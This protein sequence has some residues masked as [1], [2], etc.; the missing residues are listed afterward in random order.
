MGAGPHEK[1]FHAKKSRLNL[2]SKHLHAGFTLH[3]P[4]FHASGTRIHTI[5]S[6]VRRPFLEPH[7]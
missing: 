6:H 7:H 2:Q 1:R 5:L 3:G 4:L